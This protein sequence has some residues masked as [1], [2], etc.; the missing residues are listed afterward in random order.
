M[1]TAVA[2]G[3]NTL[4]SNAASPPL[5][6][7]HL[8]VYVVVLSSCSGRVSRGRLFW[9]PP[10]IFLLGMTQYAVLEAF[11]AEDR[12]PLPQFLLQVG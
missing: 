6:S 5:F 7:I 12:T 10:V 1:N 9:F 3:E 2:K 11:T 8:F 4:V